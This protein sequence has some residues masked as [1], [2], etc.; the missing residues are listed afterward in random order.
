ML[1]QIIR[2]SDKTEEEN[3][4]T[5][6][7]K[8][9][10]GLEK[11]FAQIGNS[12]NRASKISESNFVFDEGYR[13]GMFLSKWQRSDA[14]PEFQIKGLTAKPGEYSTTNLPCL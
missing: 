6:Q 2:F 3:N 1:P 4:L 8:S 11:V 9:L 13:V 14:G 7:C 12:L 5:E 10:K